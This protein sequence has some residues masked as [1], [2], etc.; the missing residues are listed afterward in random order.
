[1]LAST[2][3]GG[4]MS[5]KE[6]PV[7]KIRAGGIEVAIWRNESQKGPWYSVTMTR[8]YKKDEQWQQ[9]D[10]FGADDL[11]LLAKL[12]DQ[13]HNWIISQPAKRQAA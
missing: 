11:L 3:F 6:K 4:E 1:M 7:Q 8:S 10:S 9:A 5:T 2:Y 13:A 12:L